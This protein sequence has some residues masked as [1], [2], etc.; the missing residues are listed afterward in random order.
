[1]DTAQLVCH[2]HGTHISGQAVSKL[3]STV[4]NLTEKHTFHNTAHAS[5]YSTEAVITKNLK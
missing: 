2:L 1:M 5:L 3:I 4:W